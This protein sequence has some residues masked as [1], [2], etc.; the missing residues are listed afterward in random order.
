MRQST[1]RARQNLPDRHVPTL[2]APPTVKGTWITFSLLAVVVAGIC[3]GSLTE[4][5]LDTHDVE[6]FRDNLAISEDFSYFFSAKKQQPSGRPLAELIKWAGL[7]RL[8]Q[9]SVLVSPPRGC[10]APGCIYSARGMGASGRVRPSTS[11]HGVTAFSGERGP[12]PGGAPHFG[13]GLSPGPGF[14]VGCPHLL[15]QIFRQRA[16][17]LGPS[18]HRSA[19][20]SDHGAPGC[21]RGSASLY[22]LGFYLPAR[23]RNH[24]RAGVVAVAVELPLTAFLLA[25]SPA[26]PAPGRRC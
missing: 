2:P 21:Q 5:L 8:G 10:S 4:H 22:L 1:E 12:F 25:S 26:T 11:L 3:F 20:G 18:R 24:W 15:R 9:R 16:V 19:F 23:F 7:S 14:G 6:T 13:P 17:S